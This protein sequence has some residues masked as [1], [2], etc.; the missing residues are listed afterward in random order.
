MTCDWRRLVRESHSKSQL[1]V[2]PLEHTV[3]TVTVQTQVV[4]F[5]AQCTQRYAD[6]SINTS[7]T[8]TGCPRFDSRLEATAVPTHRQRHPKPI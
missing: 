5:E 6:I 8:M 7:A 1:Y 4:C 3:C 2:L